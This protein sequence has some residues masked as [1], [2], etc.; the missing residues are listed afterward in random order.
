MDIVEYPE[1]LVLQICKLEEV[2]S[3]VHILL[4]IQIVRYHFHVHFD[5]KFYVVQKTRAS[6]F[7]W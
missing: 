4:I 7:V 5:K 1:I 3:I 2:M 6:F